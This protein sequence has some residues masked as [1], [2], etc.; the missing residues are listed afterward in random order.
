MSARPKLQKRSRTSL[1]DELADD[2]KSED[3]DELVDKPEDESYRRI[4]GRRVQWNQVM[5]GPVQRELRDGG[6]S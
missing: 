5:D 1:V 4:P 2:G 6:E 3:L